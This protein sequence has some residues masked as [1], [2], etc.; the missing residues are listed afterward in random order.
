M[1]YK[2]F[3]AFAVASNS[4]VIWPFV[5]G[6]DENAALDFVM[7]IT[8]LGFN[9]LVF[10][11]TQ[12]LWGL[13]DD[14]ILEQAKYERPLL[15]EKMLHFFEKCNMLSLKAREYV[16]EGVL[17]A[18]RHAYFYNHEEYYTP[19]QLGEAEWFV[20]KLKLL[21]IRGELMEAFPEIEIDASPPWNYWDTVT[22]P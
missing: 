15:Y 9:D 2:V 1:N 14:A 12:R 6:D 19:E 7:R 18:M 4:F 17:T 21:P 8:K 13:G 11:Q 20:E 10:I 3:F 22:R 5:S 16:K